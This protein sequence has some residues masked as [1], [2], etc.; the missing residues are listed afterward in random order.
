MITHGKFYWTER[1]SLKSGGG[2][3]AAATLPL[4]ETAK[5]YNVDPQGWLPWVL[6]RTAD[7]KITL[8]DELLP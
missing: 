4:I 5:L 8:L 3:R 2:G 7:D 1:L 6:G